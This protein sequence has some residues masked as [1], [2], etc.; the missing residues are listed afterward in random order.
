MFDKTFVYTGDTNVAEGLTQF[1]SG[2]DLLLADAGLDNAD[3]TENKPHLS[4]KACGELAC[5]AGVKRLLLTHLNPKY[6]AEKLCNEA[7]SAFAGVAFTKIG[8]SY[9]I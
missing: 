5:E 1:C 8:A 9:D 2:A 3:W 7:K 4:A 6:S